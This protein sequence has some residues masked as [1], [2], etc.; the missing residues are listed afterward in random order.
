MKKLFFLILSALFLV[1]C[2]NNSKTEEKTMTENSLFE[3][4]FGDFKEIDVLA[5]Y[6]K[7]SDTSIY[8][9]DR[10]DTY[11]L[12]NLRKNGDYLVLFYK[13]TARDSANAQPISYTPL[14]TI[15]VKNLNQDE[16]ISLGYCQH[17]DM[18][19]GKY[20]PWSRE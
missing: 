6:E 18:M 11:R 14:D 10:S 12:M 3:T 9:G 16:R 5:D 17:E 4:T 20:S 7:E 2:Q 19:R 8:M 13:G 1:G 15:Q